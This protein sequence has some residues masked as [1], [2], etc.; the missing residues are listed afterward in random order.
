MPGKELVGATTIPILLTI[1]LE[2]EN[3]GY[4]LIKKVREYSG[5]KLEWSDAMLYP[6]LH[7]LQKDNLI[8]AR[9]A[10]LENGRKRK[11][12]Q[13]T[14]LGRAE[15]EERKEDWVMVLNMLSKMWNLTPAS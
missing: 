2:G 7:R 8:Q 9:W 15:L 12:Y 3:Y 11:Y 4:E 13:I 10:E 1:L 5:G 6:V 14:S